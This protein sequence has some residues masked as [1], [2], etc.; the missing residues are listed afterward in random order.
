MLHRKQDLSLQDTE[1]IY[2]QEVGR[3]SAGPLSGSKYVSK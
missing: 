3:C 1:R 2:L